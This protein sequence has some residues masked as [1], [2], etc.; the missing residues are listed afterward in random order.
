MGQFGIDDLKLAFSMH[1]VDQIV[2]ADDVLSP[3]ELAFLERRFPLSML[4]ER[5]F[6][7][8]DGER[9]E[10]WHQAAVDALE[11]LPTEL[12]ESE[13]IELLAV[14]F[15]ATIADARFERAE[16]NLLVDGARLLDLDDAVIDRFLASRAEAGG[17]TVSEL[18][19]G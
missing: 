5:G 15:E 13:K 16:G 11:R 1:M 12:T 17:A 3:E 6:A 14:F 7:H 9:T 18:D 8:A 10:A 4:V 19:E 2:A